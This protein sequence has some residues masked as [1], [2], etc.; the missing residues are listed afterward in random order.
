MYVAK[1]ESVV[2]IG[3]EEAEEGN[4]AIL[5]DVYPNPFRTVTSVVYELHQ[6]QSVTLAIYDVLG[7]RV[8]TVDRGLLPSGRHIVEVDGTGLAAGFYY[9]RIETERTVKSG[10]AIRIR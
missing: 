5:L 1:T 9:F 2:G 4:H 6:P 8:F 3:T 7:R 10:P